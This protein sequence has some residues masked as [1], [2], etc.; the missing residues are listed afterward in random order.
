MEHQVRVSTN[1][2]IVDKDRSNTIT[3]DENA[4]CDALRCLYFLHKNEIPY[5][6]NFKDLNK[7]CVMLGNDTLPNLHKS[8][9]KNYESAQTM[10]EFTNAIG[11]CLDEEILHKL[12]ASPFFSIIIDEA[13]DIALTKQLGLCVQYFDIETAIVFRSF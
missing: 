4:V 5:T 8:H 13:T 10:D 2:T 7:L 6:T 12:E 11:Y 1:T 3:V 9:N